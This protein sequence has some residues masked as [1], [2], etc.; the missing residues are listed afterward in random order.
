MIRDRTPLPD[1]AMSLREDR[2]VASWLG[3]PK[4]HGRGICGWIGP[5][6]AVPTDPTLRQLDRALL[7]V[8]R[9]RGALLLSRR[10]AR[11]A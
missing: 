3:G 11:T 5:R 8:V 9:L 2:V 10:D 4:A 7:H 6:P 1:T